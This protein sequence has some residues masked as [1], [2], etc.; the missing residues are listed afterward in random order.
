M[1]GINN[2]FAEGMSVIEI[3]F[4]SLRQEEIKEK[5]VDDWISLVS[6]FGGQAGLWLGVSMLSVMEV[7]VFC[8][9]KATSYHRMMKMK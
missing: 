5:V 2:V 3:Y 6:D 8:T 1:E 7:I 4:E 9:C